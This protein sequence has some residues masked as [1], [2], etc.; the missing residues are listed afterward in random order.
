M[1]S[2]TT[3]ALIALSFPA[4][5]AAQHRGGMPVGAPAAGHA[6]P[7]VMRAAPGAPHVAVQGAPHNNVRVQGAP[8]NTIRVAASPRTP[9]AGVRTTQRINDF[10]SDFDEFDFQDVP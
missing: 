9:G 4:C 7:V 6:G 1:R 2:L 10:R 8:S 3:F 5:T